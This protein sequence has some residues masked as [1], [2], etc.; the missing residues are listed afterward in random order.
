MAENKKRPGHPYRKKADIPA[1]Q[2]T[3]G[4]VV[5]A[6]L[7]AVFAVLVTLFAAGNNWIAL[8]IAALIG[9]TLGYYIGKSM[10]KEASHR[11]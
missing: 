8:I 4:R 3:K 1:S 9:S 5:W 2:R 10:E 6:L 11:S 7:I